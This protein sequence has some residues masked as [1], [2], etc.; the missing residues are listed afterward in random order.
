MNEDI[1]FK[2]LE[3]LGTVS[4]FKVVLYCVRFPWEHLVY[5]RVC[6]V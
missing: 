1:G 6:P 5:R 4:P 3:E 2:V